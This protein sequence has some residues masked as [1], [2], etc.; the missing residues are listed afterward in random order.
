MNNPHDNWPSAT[1]SYTTA[2]N[3]AG[4]L[5]YFRTHYPERERIQYDVPFKPLP[6]GLLPFVVAN[7]PEGFQAH[8]ISRWVA[9][10][11][12]TALRIVWKGGPPCERGRLNPLMD[13]LRARYG[14]DACR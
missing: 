9:G 11:Y 10:C 8:Q 3:P 1:G 12:S 5:L 7:L 2:I 13:E 14:D 6:V 4:Y